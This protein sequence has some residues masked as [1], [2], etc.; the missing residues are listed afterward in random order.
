MNTAYYP[1]CNATTA[2]PTHTQSHHRHDYRQRQFRH[3]VCLR[4]TCG[5]QCFALHLAAVSM[6]S[7]FVRL[8]IIRWRCGTKSYTQ[9]RNA[10]VHI[11]ETIASHTIPNQTTNKPTQTTTHVC[12]TFVT[13]QYSFLFIY[14]CIVFECLF[15]I[16][17]YLRSH[18]MLIA[19]N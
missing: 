3:H 17:T 7:D 18:R 14:C 15:S 2:I 16:R 6:G 1:H 4:P 11:N 10:D 8:P 12:F 19:K 9:H 13:L 5:E